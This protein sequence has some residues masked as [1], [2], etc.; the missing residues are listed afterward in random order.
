MTKSPATATLTVDVNPDGV[1]LITLDRPPVNALDLGVLEELQLVLDEQIA[2]EARAIVLTARGRCFCAGIDTK[3]V[4]VYD[5]AQRRATVAGLNR[6]VHTLYTAPVPVVAALNGHA[7]GGGVVLPLAC[8]RRLIASGEISVGL[9]EVQAGV[10]YPAAAMHI[11][12]A[13]LRPAVAREL[14]LTARVL[15]PQEALALEVVDR[16]CAPDALVAQAVAHAAEL[17]ELPAY[18]RVKQQLRQETAELT[19]VVVTQEL[20]PMLDSW[21]A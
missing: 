17:A 2:G 8:D 5:A 12:R 3:L 15:S 7:L 6:V 16:V 21:L 9:T 13:E 10:P 18:A 19:H 1:A 11:V 14:C 20:D 4:A